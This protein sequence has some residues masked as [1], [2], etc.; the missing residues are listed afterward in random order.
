MSYGDPDTMDWD[1]DLEPSQRDRVMNRTAMAMG[2]Q[3]RYGNFAVGANEARKHGYE[4][5][6]TQGVTM[7]P[8]KGV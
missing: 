7:K 8:G 4:D 3:P 5:R 2:L 6:N 1:D